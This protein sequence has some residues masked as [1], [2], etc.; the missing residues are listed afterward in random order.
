M[1]MCQ[2]E[3]RIQRRITLLKKQIYKRSK[4]NVIDLIMLEQLEELKAQKAQ[5]RR[6][7]NWEAWYLFPS[8]PSWHV[9]IEIWK[10]RIHVM[11]PVSVLCYMVCC[12]SAKLSL[13]MKQKARLAKNARKLFGSSKKLKRDTC[14][15][16]LSSL[17]APWHRCVLQNAGFSKL[18]GRGMEKSIVCVAFCA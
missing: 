15:Y 4:R 3:R 11:S 8:T 5:A 17:V 12:H 9:R 14:V 13:D 6:M 18:H 16:S 1:P 7:R 2:M 10:K